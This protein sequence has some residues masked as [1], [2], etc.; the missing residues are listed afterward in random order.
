MYEEAE[1]SEFAGEAG[2]ESIQFRSP[3]VF[4]AHRGP[5]MVPASACDESSVMSDESAALIKDLG[6]LTVSTLSGLAELLLVFI[7]AAV[8]TKASSAPAAT[9]ATPIDDVADI[10][11]LREWSW[12]LSVNWVVSSSLRDGDSTVT[13]STPESQLLCKLHTS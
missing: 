7:K 6:Q 1:N 10:A 13:V 5:V 8:P 11:L 2:V 12:A 4:A 3:P 9:T